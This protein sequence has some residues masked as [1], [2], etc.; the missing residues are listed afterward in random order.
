MKFLT[1]RVLK[2]TAALVVARVIDLLAKV[3]IMAKIS[4]YFGPEIFGEYAFIISLV[5][6]GVAFTY[7][8]IERITIRN[9]AQ[10]KEEERTTLGTALVTRWLLS[11]LVMLILLVLTMTIDF[12]RNEKLAILVT[13]ISQLAFSSAMLYGAV[14]KAYERMEYETLLTFLFQ[15][16]VLVLIFAVIRL[17]LGFIPVFVAL[18]IANIGRFLASMLLSNRKFFRPK[19][20]IDMTMIKVLLKDSFILGINL[21]IV[22]V[23]LRAD[24]FLLKAMTTGVEVSLFYIP[25]SLLLH[26]QVLPVAF[27]TAVFPF[28]SRAAQDDR[29]ALSYGFEKSFKLLLV[30][31][32]FVVIAGMLSASEIITMICGQ[33]YVAATLSFQ[34]LVPGMIFLFLHPLLSFVLISTNRQSL[35]IPASIGALITNVSLA[36]IFIPI[37]GNVGASIASLAGYAV[38]FCLTLYFVVRR[39]VN[40]RLGSILFKPLIA[41]ALMSPVIYLLKEQ[42]LVLRI[43]IALIAYGISLVVLRVFS[44]DEIDIVR[45]ITKRVWRN[46]YNVES[47]NK[48]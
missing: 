48:E 38:L 2:N 12:G 18:A 26:L 25:Q 13:I 32:G 3:L 21:L 9:I 40:V 30:A 47:G 45:K 15:L 8:G 44:D 7:F 41:L 27:A 11:F 42:A 4:R 14:F 36:L 23:I 35:L 31:S 16:V 33:A 10:N 34:I 1:D 17:D 19:M 43:L 46:I 39:V 28:F 20:A 37:Y 5:A 6:F 24:V 29:Q 22:Q